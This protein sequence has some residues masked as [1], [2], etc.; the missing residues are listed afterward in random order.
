[1]RLEAKVAVDLTTEPVKG[2]PLPLES[3]DNVHGSD[4]LTLGML[5]VSDRITDHILKEVLEDTTGLFIDET[6]DALNTT[7]T[8]E[9]ANG[10]LGDALDVITQDLAMTFRTT[11]SKT[12]ATFTT[13]RHDSMYAFERLSSNINKGFTKVYY[14]FIVPHVLRQPISDEHAKIPNAYVKCFFVS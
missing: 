6:A 3:V 5:G 4:C 7:S 13:S 2:L 11:L 1:M 12:L 9:T 10:G 14:K 8:S